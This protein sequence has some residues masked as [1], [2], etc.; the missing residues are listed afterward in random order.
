MT[1]SSSEINARPL[2]AVVELLKEYVEKCGW[3]WVEA[4]VIEIRRRAK[5]TQVLTLRD[6]IQ[7]VSVSVTCSAMVATA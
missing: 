2:H 3:I 4:Q 5:P 6:H 7:D 1:Q